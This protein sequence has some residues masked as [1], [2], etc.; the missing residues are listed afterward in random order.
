MARSQTGP[1]MAWRSAS[2]RPERHS[3]LRR[4]NVTIHS[5]TSAGVSLVRPKPSSCCFL[6]PRESKRRA[7]GGSPAIL[8]PAWRQKLVGVA[9]EAK[10][11]G[12]ATPA[13]AGYALS[14]GSDP[15]YR[16]VLLLSIGIL[17]VSDAYTRCVGVALSSRLS[18]CETA[19]AGFSPLRPRV[20]ANPPAVDTLASR[21]TASVPSQP[22]G[23]SRAFVSDSSRC[24]AQPNE[25]AN[26]LQAL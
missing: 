10:T 24:S 9:E 25:N 21:S 16:S 20:A 19:C 11:R 13:L 17:I 2:R 4:L 1:V 14:N 22:P 18:S 8:G 12:F 26:Q 15:V 7:A 5:R 3:G 23:P 6:E